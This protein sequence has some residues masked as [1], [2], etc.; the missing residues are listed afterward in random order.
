M[1]V[2]DLLSGN[3]QL[4]KLYFDSFNAANPSFDVIF[5]HPMNGNY[6]CF[7]DGLQNSNDLTTTLN[8]N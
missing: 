2:P 6:Y 4:L 1:F 8:P 7:K 5:N 3:Q